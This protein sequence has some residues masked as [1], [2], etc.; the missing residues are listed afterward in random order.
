MFAIIRKKSSLLI[1]PTK[2]VNVCRMA[3]IVKN[4]SIQILWQRSCIHTLALVSFSLQGRACLTPTVRL[5]DTICASLL[6]VS[7]GLTLFHPI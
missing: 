6:T 7:P 3:N 1:L 4:V 5:E 2:I